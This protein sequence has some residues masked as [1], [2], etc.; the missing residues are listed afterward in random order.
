MYALVLVVS[1]VL[2]FVLVFGLGSHW[3]SGQWG[4][5]A[6]WISGCSTFAAVLV[7]LWQTVIAREAAAKSA[8]EA[9]A[10]K[11]QAVLDSAAAN[12]EADDR[13][14]R[15]I[16]AYRDRVEAQLKKSDE[17]YERRAR[18]EALELQ[19]SE[20][21]RLWPVVGETLWAAINLPVGANVVGD[22][23]N[24]WEEQRKELSFATSR[25]KLFVYDT[26]VLAAIDWV[27]DAVNRFTD[28][29]DMVA[30]GEMRFGNP[31]GPGHLREMDITAI[32]AARTALQ[33]KASARLTDFAPEAVLQRAA[34]WK[35]PT[36]TPETLHPEGEAGCESSMNGDGGSR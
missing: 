8:R 15:E 12:R 36:A 16:A 4:D 6:T 20:F 3:G 18:A 27:V 31:D 25:A 2:A 32:R 21:M 13:L 22:P 5:V 29:V 17:L 33:D 19:R 24:Q 9:A 30:S 26:E 1:F 11:E 14:E 35:S 23:R 10:A 34:A 28:H 7:A